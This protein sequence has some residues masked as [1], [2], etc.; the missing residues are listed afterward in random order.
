MSRYGHSP[1]Q[2]PVAD[3]FERVDD[4]VQRVREM[5]DQMSAEKELR[6]ALQ[7]ELKDQQEAMDALMDMLEKTITVEDT[8]DLLAE[9][10]EKVGQTLRENSNEIS[11]INKDVAGVHDKLE[12]SAEHIVARVEDVGQELAGEAARLEQ[13]M[14][15]LSDGMDEKVTALTDR[16]DSRLSGMDTKREQGSEALYGTVRAVE[17][18]LTARVEEVHRNCSAKVEDLTSALDTKNSVLSKTL[19]DTAESLRSMMEQNLEI[20]VA[21]VNGSAEA[22][23]A[24][25]ERSNHVFREKLAAEHDVLT[26]TMHRLEQKTEA[27]YTELRTRTNSEMQQARELASGGISKLN[28]RL[29]EELKDLLDRLT[30]GA[31]DRDAA[32]TRIDSKLVESCEVMQSR[33]NQQLVVL[34]EKVATVGKAGGDSMKALHTRVESYIL[35]SDQFFR[36]VGEDKKVAQAAVRQVDSKLDEASSALSRDLERVRDQSSKMCS[37]LERELSGRIVGLDAMAR[38]QYST[39]SDSCNEADVRHRTKAAEIDGRLEKLDNDVVANHSYTTTQVDLLERKTEEMTVPCIEQLSNLQQELKEARDDLRRD[40]ESKDAAQNLRIDNQQRHFLTSCNN[41]KDAVTV[42]VV[43]LQTETR[44]HHREAAEAVATAKAT[45]ERKIDDVEDSRKREMEQVQTGLRTTQQEVIGHDQ[46]VASILQRMSRLDNQVNDNH[47]QITTDVNRLDSTCIEMKDVMSEQVDTLGKTMNAATKHFEQDRVKLDVK[48]ARKAQEQDARLDE[49]DKSGQEVKVHFTKFCA[50]LQQTTAG[51]WDHFNSVFETLDQRFKSRCDS[52]D[53]KVEQERQYF[54]GVCAEI[55]SGSTAA[56]AEQ[57]GATEKFVTEFHQVVD[58]LETKCMG[59]LGSQEKRLEL[60]DGPG[61]SIENTKKL[62][63]DMCGSLN[64]QMLLHNGNYEDTMGKLDEKIGTESKQMVETTMAIETRFLK[65]NA[66]QDERV[67][68]QEASF[69]QECKKLAEKLEKASTSQ[70]DRASKFEAEAQQQKELLIGRCQDLD[71]QFSK[72]MKEQT[73]SV[74]SLSDTCQEN[75]QQLVQVSAKLE[76]AFTQNLTRAEARID[77]VVRDISQSNDRFSTL[78]RELSKST[79]EQLQSHDQAMKIQQQ[80]FN[81]LLGDLHSKIDAEVEAVDGRVEAVMQHCLEVSEVTNDTVEKNDAA[82]QVRTRELK[83][84]NETQTLRLDTAIEALNKRISSGDAEHTKRA[85]SLQSDFDDTCAKLDAKF[86]AVQKGQD[87]KL[88]QNAEG[89]RANHN[90]TVNDVTKLAQ[91]MA[92]A[93]SAQAASLQERFEQLAACCNDITQTVNA[94]NLEQDNLIVDVGNTVNKHHQ[95][96]EDAF[97]TRDAKVL[98]KSKVQDERIDSVYQHFTE[99]FSDLEK[100]FRDA[101]QDATINRLSSAVQEHYDEFMT[102]HK[103]ADEKLR[104]SETQVSERMRTHFNHI[105]DV[106]RDLDQKCLDRNR[107][108][109][110]RTDKLVTTI[111]DGHKRMIDLCDHLDKK[112]AGEN[113]AQDERIAALHEHFTEVCDDLAKRFRFGEIETRIDN[114]TNTVQENHQHFTSVC[115]NLDMKFGDKF[116]AQ[117][118]RMETQRLHFTEVSTTL[119]DKFRSFMEHEHE[120]FTDVTRALDTRITDKQNSFEAT[121]SELKGTVLENHQHVTTVCTDMDRHFTNM[122]RDVDT[123][124]TEQNASQ[125]ERVENLSTHFMNICSNMDQAFKDRNAAHDARTE[126]N[127]RHFTDVQKNLEMQLAGKVEELRGSIQENHR[128]VSGAVTTVDTWCRSQLSAHASRIDEMG[129]H[130]KENYQHFAG[131]CANLDQTS[132]ERQEHF[133]NV[134]AALDEK[135]T[136]KISV[137]DARFGSEHRHLVDVCVNLDHKWME[138]NVAQDELIENQRLRL[139]DVNTQLDQKFS[140]KTTAQD[141]RMDGLTES[142][143]KNR[144]VLTDQC[145]NVDKRL[146]AKAV[147]QDEQLNE[148]RDVGEAHHQHFTDVSRVMDKKFVEANAAQDE[149]A[150]VQYTHFTQVASKLDAKFEEKN[151]SQDEIIVT[152]YQHFTEV[153][154]KLND[155]LEERAGAQDARMDGL[156]SQQGADHEHFTQVIADL[157]SRMLEK[158]GAHDQLIGSHYQHFTEICSTLDRKCESKTNE[159]ELRVSDL[160]QAQDDRHAH[161]SAVCN[162]MDKKFSGAVVAVRASIAKLLQQTD[163]HD[164]RMDSISASAVEAERRS[165]SNLA[166]LERKCTSEIEGQG[167]RISDNTTHFTSVCAAMEAR[168]VAKDDEQQQ[169]ASDMNDTMHEHHEQQAVLCMKLEAKIQDVDVGH[170]ERSQREHDHFTDTAAMLDE[171]LD[172]K[173]VGLND[174]TEELAMVVSDHFLQATQKIGGLEQTFLS[175]MEEHEAAQVQRYQHCNDMVASLGRKVDENA[176]VHSTKTDALRST[177]QEHHEYFTSVCDN[178]DLKFTDKHAVQDAHFENQHRH[179]TDLCGKINQTFH[180]RFAAQDERVNAIGNAVDEHYESLTAALLRLDRRSEELQGEQ[181]TLFRDH[182]EHFTELCDSLDRK[183][184]DS[185]AAQSADTSALSASL[186]RQQQQSQ[187]D[188]ENLDEKMTANHNLVEQRVSSHYEHFTE[189]CAGLDQKL[190]DKIASHDFRMDELSLAVQERHDALAGGIAALDDKIGGLGEQTD[191]T[192]RSQHAHFTDLCESMQKQHMNQIAAEQARTDELGG[193]VE[194]QREHFAATLSMMDTRNGQKF[195]THHERFQDQQSHFANLYATLEE[196]LVQKNDAQDARI[197]EIG[198]AVQEN[199]Q[200]L[201]D[202]CATLDEKIVEDNF[203]QDQKSER[204][205]QEL[206]DTCSSIDKKYL[207]HVAEQDARMDEL[208]NAMRDHHQHFTDLC[209]NMD[210]KFMGKSTQLKENLST[211]QQSLTDVCANLDQKFGERLENQK[212]LCSDMCTALDKK[213]GEKGLTTENRVDEL[214]SALLDHHRHFTALNGSLEKKIT[215]ETQLQEDRN[216]AQYAQL[217]TTCASIDQKFGA[218]ASATDAR[219]DELAAVVEDH[220]RNF[221]FVC[222]KLETKFTEENT[223]QNERMEDQQMHFSQVYEAMDKKFTLESSSQLESIEVLQKAVGDDQAHFGGLCSELEEKISGVESTMEERS[224]QLRDHFTHN[225]SSI[226]ATFT[227]A[228]TAQDER[229][230]MH[231]KHLTGVCND[232]EAVMNQRGTEQD[233]RM[234]ELGD[235][236][237]Q[238]YTHCIGI[239]SELDSTLTQKMDAQDERVD[240]ISSSMDEMF[241]ISSASIERL[242]QKIIEESGLRDARAA[243]LEQ[244]VNDACAS[245]DGKINVEIETLATTVEE[246]SSDHLARTEHVSEQ[247]RQQHEH[248]THVCAQLDQQAAEKHVAHAELISHHR[249]LSTDSYAAL[250][251]KYAEAN[252]AQDQRSNDQHEDL[253]KM[254]RTLNDQFLQQSNQLDA[255]FTDAVNIVD[256]KYEE[257]IVAHDQRMDEEHKHFSDICADLNSNLALEHAALDEKFIEVCTKLDKK[258]LEANSAQAERTE[259]HYRHFAD[260]GDRLEKSLSH[261]VINLSQR[262]T[263]EYAAH[264]EQFNE[265]GRT[266]DAN[267]EQLADRCA[268]LDK[269]VSENSTAQDVRVSDLRATTTSSIS[270]LEL[271]QSE[272][273]AKLGSAIEAAHSGLLAKNVELDTKLTNATLELQQNYAA[274]VDSLAAEVDA[275]HKSVTDAVQSSRRES[276]SARTEVEKVLMG[277]IEG[278]DSESRRKFSELT[279]GVAESQNVLQERH[280]QLADAC[281]ELNNALAADKVAAEQ[282]SESQHRHFTAISSKL[283]AKYNAVNASLDHKVSET[284]AAHSLRMDNIQTAL[285]G[286]EAHFGGLCKSID[287]KC[288]ERHGSQANKTDEQYHHTTESL[289]KLESRFVEESSARDHLIEEHHLQFSTICASLDRKLTEG[290]SNLDSLFS[291]TCNRMQKQFS[292]DA[293]KQSMRI[294]AEHQHFT[295]VCFKLDNTMTEANTELNGRCGLLCASLDDKHSAYNAGLQERLDDLGGLFT[296]STDTLNKSLVDKCDGLH[297]TFSERSSQHGEQIQVLGIKAEDDHRHFSALC[298]DMAQKFNDNITEIE[299]GLENQHKHFTAV[300]V[301]VDE[302]FAEENGMQDELIE[303]H[304]KHFSTISANLD[305]KFT[306]M[307]ANLD[308]K[309]TS[310]CTQLEWQCSEKNASQDKRMEADH[311]HFATLI[312]NT[313]TKLTDALV[314]LDEKIAGKTAVQDTRIEELSAGVENHHEYFTDV[315]YR[316]DK[317]FREKN[318]EQDAQIH[319]HHEDFAT[320]VSKL[321]AKL[322]QDL[323][324]VDQNLRERMAQ[325]DAQSAAIHVSTQQQAEQVLLECRSLDKKFTAKDSAQDDEIRDMHHTFSDLISKL[326]KRISDG[327]SDTNERIAGEHKHFG[328]LCDG[329]ER[330]FAQ[331]TADVEARSATARARMEHQLSTK[332]ADHEQQIVDGRRQSGERMAKF[333]SMLNELEGG[334]DDKLALKFAGLDSKISDSVAELGSQREHFTDVCYNLDKRFTAERVEK[335]EK[336]EENHRH[337]VHM[338]NILDGKF[339]EANSELR[340]AVA[341]KNAVQDAQ[342]GEHDRKIQLN[343]DHFTDACAKQARRSTEKNNEQDA[344]IEAHRSHFSDGMAGLEKKWLEDSDLM[345]E[346]L[347]SDYEALN[348]KVA[349]LGRNTLAKQAAMDEKL[350]GADAALGLKLTTLSAMQSERVDETGRQ[351]SELCNKLEAKHETD[352]W[353]VQKHFQK[354]NADTATRINTSITRVETR[355]DK[356]HKMFTDLCADLDRKVEHTTDAVDVK[357]TDISGKLDKKFTDAL[358]TSQSLAEQNYRQFSKQC[359]AIGSSM[360]EADAR[361]ESELSARVMAVEATFTTVTTAHGTELDKQRREQAA[362]SERL[363]TTLLKADGA[364]ESKFTAVF[365]QLNQLLTDRTAQIEL[366]VDSDHKLFADLCAKLEVLCL[367]R[368]ANLEEKLGTTGASLKHELLEKDR[369]VRLK[370]DAAIAE[371]HTYTT[372]TGAKLEKDL[373]AVSRLLGQTIDTT[374]RTLAGELVALKQKVDGEIADKIRSLGLDTT[375]RIDELRNLVEDK[376]QASIRAVE[377]QVESVSASVRQEMEPKLVQFHRQIENLQAMLSSSTLDVNELKSSV[378]ATVEQL[379]ESVE[380]VTAAVAEISSMAEINSMMMQAASS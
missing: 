96:F 371:E 223:V 202:L 180:E 260:M 288:M 173:F 197:G 10:E 194:E 88:V 184:A 30:K 67:N 143:E 114:I 222:D 380:T 87:G 277:R 224:A 278:V 258:F 128:A 269:T 189:A 336:I 302:K 132:K 86:T 344:L 373:Q 53:E 300:S 276:S 80:Q 29:D 296:K 298:A 255:R 319:E 308:E 245:L 289:L 241:A 137:H 312:S 378:T 101:E 372:G 357:Q 322:S 70:N 74:H 91:K 196:N 375:G 351:C 315:C 183:I 379:A 92:D 39:L 165:D 254:Y 146:T 127:S 204:L 214:S 71:D 89:I 3:D 135:F 228:N 55:Q 325:Q 178:L 279:H 303:D 157:D 57:K 291:D 45:L 306:E 136:D 50:D 234:N 190:S 42:M 353:N 199:Y 366:R 158:S 115:A 377:K 64:E 252:A 274:K 263:E 169:R 185:H 226:E 328:D 253:Q 309:F 327:V 346:L 256:R 273:S 15:E 139:I 329:L 198:T 65:L 347:V 8:N 192:L 35:D 100:R 119:A 168:L 37:T 314:E 186:Q 174:R 348:L 54:N 334:L 352:L 82:Q 16:V 210:V 243:D 7:T 212:D 25:F 166:E 167:V 367:E 48:Y 237:D 78:H 267:Q 106:A 242:E 343:F 248:F 52:L 200:H 281:G 27:R 236:L 47:A 250:E 235:S 362:D 49:L 1:R 324:A 28:G 282:R 246:N 138:K 161:F 209:E 265:L 307:T 310:A 286:V 311:T 153:C 121:F 368:S 330:T 361:I 36:A 182:H 159:T 12:A 376:V 34:D 321:D 323:T 5:E 13:Q 257:K 292:E 79:A 358:A 41:D 130:V 60:V 103:Q 19:K 259:E 229:V 238:N 340:Q 264:G 144:Q 181:Q 118:E 293:T 360:S 207:Q 129:Q 84:E 195:A 203:L 218:K 83:G 299:E 113:V 317:K 370:L 316:M 145:S 160:A 262:L 215:R 305:K 124:F 163:A 349:D 6:V 9:L 59:G 337:V 111:A 320:T 249:K 98:S 38:Q 231:H 148:L 22:L 85:D 217:S 304:H 46:A 350:T 280:Q 326:D 76:D 40:M 374:E 58:E 17:Q 365:V 104:E 75:F 31:G 220:H 216:Q 205:H 331:E 284:V 191:E 171:K 332:I 61:G 105:T 297:A 355:V 338:C 126:N 21:K 211:L 341:E 318:E 24:D 125:D 131:V 63:N 172:A 294:D 20:N 290:H 99:A 268:R 150:Q 261:E 219:T 4:V 213:F 62:V 187:N 177:M 33:F 155:K 179:F 66:A 23:K 18:A 120:H 26:A 364:L 72:D 151:E 133:E 94:K 225:F 97:T 149:R 44:T 275:K 11:R 356:E 295:D 266:V 233:G 77:G 230:E 208:G 162:S 141:A 102:M 95:H 247:L 170:I 116:V 112:F 147:E 251:I 272:E 43:E 156:S 221:T 244:H 335:D 188:Y 342:F 227:E 107:E 239:T 359:T 134:C 345:R 109:D 193:A 93:D 287:A 51:H 122:C 110:V 283:D 90:Q 285:H 73:L 333:E 301:R 81:E 270:M 363:E 142:I 69:S 313:D 154:A 232:L 339:T 32:L 117:E 152:H 354:L 123:K 68:R 14:S 175:K 176:T 56:N 206:L 369:Q 240:G 201:I 108:Q 2:E 271:Q 140:S 164:V